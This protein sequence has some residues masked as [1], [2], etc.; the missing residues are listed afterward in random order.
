MNATTFT[1]RWNEVKGILMEKYGQISGDELTRAQGDVNRLIGI[2]QQKTGAARDEI[3]QFLEKSLDSATGVASR[4][5]DTT[6]SYA[7]E[8]MDYARQNYGQVSE[9]AQ[10]GYEVTRD[11]VKR[12]PLE[13]VAI[14]FGAGAMAGLL[15][16]LL[17]QPRR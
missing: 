15:V 3:E 5:A 12:S 1:G 7:N 9:A 14:A 2:V 13:S 8:A 17:M 4:L 11:Y 10:Q 16:A 6:A